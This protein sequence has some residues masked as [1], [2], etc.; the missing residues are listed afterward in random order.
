LFADFGTITSCK[1][2]WTG[3]SFCQFIFFPV[4]FDG[5]HVYMGCIQGGEVLLVDLVESCH[6]Y[7][8][9]DNFLLI[10]GDERP[11]GTEPWIWF[12]CFF[13][14]RRSHTCSMLFEIF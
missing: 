2:S 4:T 12:C 5:D 1:V 8:V 14:S 13:I 10:A 9:I 3:F 6:P 11:S 7:V